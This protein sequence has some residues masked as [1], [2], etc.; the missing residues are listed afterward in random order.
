ME[1]LPVFLLVDG[2]NIGLTARDGFWSFLHFISTDI[3]TKQAINITKAEN[4]TT[5][6]TME[7]IFVFLSTKLALIGNA[8]P[9][10]GGCVEEIPVN[11]TF[12]AAI[13]EERI[14]ET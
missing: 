10:A 11:I 1:L 4:T 14:T 3:V 13:F 7:F 9:L 12:S 6:T 5:K 8:G 2:M